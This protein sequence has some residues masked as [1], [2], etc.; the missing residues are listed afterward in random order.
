[1]GGANKGDLLLHETVQQKPTIQSFDMILSSMC[2]YEQI[3][4][5]C[6]VQLQRDK[7]QCFHKHKEGTWWRKLGGSLS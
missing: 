3:I 7:D 4:E 6:I 1:M 5:F 2:A